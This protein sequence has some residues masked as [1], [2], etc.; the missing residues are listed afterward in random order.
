MTPTSHNKLLGTLHL[1]YGAINVLIVIGVSIFVL[2]M[3]GIIARNNGAE[4]FPFG[5]IALVM[6]LVVGINMLL[7][8]PSF[9]AGYA[10]LK[11]KRWAKTMGI[12][13]ATLAGL[14]FP[15]GSV[16][17]V[18]T[19]WFLFGEGGR[20]LY[21]KAAYALS[22]GDALWA[23]KADREPVREYLPPSAPPDWR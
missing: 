10:F 12:I 15:L 3:M 6:V 13:A 1:V 21:H 18:Y 2:M 16:L 19:L 17:C 14:N 22:P 4:P 5:F 23:R 8:T 20:F 9:L 11:R 7:I